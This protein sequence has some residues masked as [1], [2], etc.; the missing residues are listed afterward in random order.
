MRS[1]TSHASRDRRKINKIYTR[2]RE[3]FRE[4]STEY[5]MSI[6]TEFQSQTGVPYSLLME[7]II[8]TIASAALNANSIV[9]DIGT[10]TGNVAFAVADKLPNLE[11]IGI[12]ISSEMLRKASD[13]KDTGGG[14]QFIFAPGE[15]PP[16]KNSSVDGIIC[17]FCAHHL[18][19]QAFDSIS[20]ILKPGGWL[21]IVDV[22]PNPASG[23]LDNIVYTLKR[24]VEYRRKRSIAETYATFY[25]PEDL[26]RTLGGRA[27]ETVSTK[28]FE[29]P[30]GEE[31]YFL[32]LF[33]K[34]K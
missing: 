18:Q 15:W 14:P 1:D 33:R 28:V 8:G 34:T 16:L 29:N 6:E 25:T 22:G 31:P 9:C 23:F 11:I 3:Q 30:K 7:S 20:Q 13:K 2:I 5:D 17:T 27:I 24:F 12:D 21:L 10:G 19:N 32:M 4:R 26:T